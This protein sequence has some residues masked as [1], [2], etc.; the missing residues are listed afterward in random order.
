MSKISQ[1]KGRKLFRTSVQIGG[2]RHFIKGK[3]EAA[4]A[5]RLAEVWAQD[6]ASKPETLT[7]A[8]AA[9]KFLA[10]KEHGNQDTFRYLLHHLTKAGSMPKVMGHLVLANI[11]P[12]ELTSFL[13]D[14]LKCTSKRGAK[15]SPQTVNHERSALIQIFSFALQTG[16]INGTAI[17]WRTVKKLR[18][19]ERSPR[20]ISDADLSAFYAVCPVEY[21]PLFDIF[22]YTGLR[23]SEAK[24]MEWDW[25]DLKNRVL[26]V[27]ASKTTKVDALPLCDAAVK[28]FEALP[29]RS[30]FVVEANFGPIL[31]NNGIHSLLRSL[32]RQAKIKRF[33]LHPFRHTFITNIARATK[34]AL[35]TE[36]LARHRDP[37]MTR[38]YMD[39]VAEDF[40]DEVELLDGRLDKLT[41]NEESQ[42][43]DRPKATFRRRKKSGAPEAVPQTVPKGTESGSGSEF[44]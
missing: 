37:K 5:R 4:V 42:G 10:A 14:R 25:V 34:N 30:G 31:E 3:T 41:S 11:T 20:C 16:L 12:N 24:R 33:G 6:K 40:R 1:V 32:T 44:S 36:K 29:N 27:K 18:V 19:P 2:V 13:N 35:A 17:N 23:L 7:L 9:A 21:R 28:A 26:I 39:M 22:L 43:D 15:L 8:D 38:R